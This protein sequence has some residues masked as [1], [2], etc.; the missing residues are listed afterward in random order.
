MADIADIKTSHRVIEIV[1]PK[2]RQPIGLRWTLASLQ[3]ER[4]KAAQRAITDRRLYL[5]ARNKNFKADDLEDNMRNLQ[6][7][8][9]VGWEWYE[10]KEERDEAGAITKPFI[11]QLTFHGEVPDFNKRNVVAVLKELDWVSAQINEAIGEVE[12]FFD[13]SKP[14]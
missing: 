14:N 10:Q 12:D 3:D 1:H 4:T 7:A 11:E 8:A 13:N 5:E 6:F 2:T 9:T